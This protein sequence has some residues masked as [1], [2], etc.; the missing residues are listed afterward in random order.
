[1]TRR[2]RAFK[3]WMRSHGIECSDALELVET[4]AT[5]GI[6]VRALCDLREGDLVATIPKNAC[7]TI[8]TSGAR[9]MIEE[10]GLSGFLGLAVAVMFERSLGPRS[11]WDA[12][13]QLLPERECVPLVWSA[14]EVDA[15][16]GGT[17]L[18]KAVKE[19]R[20]F[21]YEDWRDSIE[22]LIHGPWKL[23]S[24]SFGV[25]QYFSAKTLISSRSFEIDSFHGSGMVPL[26]DLFNHKTG[27]E[28]VHFTSV[29]SSPSTSDD[30]GDEDKNDASSDEQSSISFTANSSGDSNT[31]L[32]MIIVR[33]ANAGSEVFN[34]YGSMGNAALL[35]RYGFT[36]SDNPFDI[37]NIDLTL[38]VRWCSST[39]SDRYARARLSSWR[40]LSYTGCTSQNSEYFEI[41][42]NGEPQLELLVLLYIIFLPEDAFDKLR[43]MIETLEITDDCTSVVNMLKITRGNCHKP[44]KISNGHEGSS[45]LKKLLLT[46]NVCGALLSLADL[47]ESL[48]DSSSLDDDVRRLQ[49]CSY[50]NDRKQYHS[51]VLRMSE[52][53]ILQRLRAHASRRSRLKKRKLK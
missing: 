8:R 11:P 13:L 41:S 33:D 23:D 3:R 4:A 15:L 22:P 25:E 1:M 18:E 43:Y 14:E 26:A 52:R 31:A 30:E 45:Y 12:Y 42:Y 36:E 39:F 7:L 9:A 16:L 27:A 19:D 32:E 2:L 6:C 53:R 21:I 51:L 46:E 20:S 49:E 47:R 44:L 37:I 34:T 24:S 38:I 48:Y 29:T 5:N 40:K 50:I 28:N 35:H 10:A 17:E